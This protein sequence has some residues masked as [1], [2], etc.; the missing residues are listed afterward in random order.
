MSERGA[1]GFTEWFRPGEQARTERA[2]AAMAATGATHLR[3]HLSWAEYHTPG[4][5]DW[6]DWLLPRAAARFELLPCIHYTPPSLSRSGSAASPPRRLLDY[7]DFVDH[8][9]TRYGRHFRAVE[10]WNEPN[11][12]LDW[13]WR[14][15]PDWSLFCEMVGAAAHWARRRGFTTVLGGPCPFDAHWLRLMGERGVLA[16]IDALG[17]HGFPGTWDSERGSWNGWPALIG[18][19]RGILDAHNPQAAIWITEAGYATWRNDEA[20]QAR[21]F[22][23]ALAAPAARLYWYGWQD[24]PDSVA[25]QEGLRFDQRHYHMGVVDAEGHPKLLARLLAESGTQGVARTLTLA[26]PLLQQPAQPIVITGG[27]GFIGC[28]LADSYLRE[29]R[30]VVVLDNLSRPGVEQNLAWLKDRHGDRLSWQAADLRDEPLMRELLRDAGAVFHLAA[31]TAVTTS[32]DS[33]VADFEV[34]ARGTLNLLEAVRRSGRATPVIFASTNKVYGNLG[35]LAMLLQED[36]CVPADTVVAMRGIGEQRPLDFCTPYGC[37][38]GVADQYVL[39][40]AQSYGLPTAVL[41]M[42]CIYG[43][44]Q[45]GTEDQGWVAHFVI[46]AL[47]GEPI[48]LYGDG[49]QVRDILHV[50]DAVAAYRALLSR[51]DALRGQA[52]NLGG[53]PAN[54]VSLRMVLR[55]IARLVGHEPV[56]SHGETRQGDQAYFVADTTKLEAALGWAPRIAWRPGLEDL[57]GWLAPRHRPVADRLR[58]IA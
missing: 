44:R 36:R 53:G 12:L 40:Y 33:P 22:L 8:A 41:R 30:D 17:L 23:D 18:A 4:G 2:L 55:E 47:R 25:V 10:L 26:A 32:L 35:D 29:G 54:A 20:A 24:I 28:N 13:D 5:P 51:I 46:R 21:S 1:F 14:E 15:D 27:A 50:Q 42:S 34:N 43:P 56:V 45:F 49:R 58:L 37:S 38:K 3:T 9:L 7:A 57:H 39:D 11:N 6:Y 52:F 48:T 31:Q 19:A 16:E